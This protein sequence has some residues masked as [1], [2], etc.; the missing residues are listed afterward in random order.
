MTAPSPKVRTGLDRLAGGDGPTFDGRRVAL[1]AHPASVTADL[2]HARDVLA[3]RGARLVSLF[4]PEHGVFGAAQDM[5]AVT[6]AADGDVPVHSLYGDDPASLSPRPEHFHGADVLVCDLADIGVRY[7]TYA[8]TVVLA[9]EVALAAGIEVFVLDRPNP[10]GGAAD[11]LE[12]AAVEPGYDSFVGLH[13][14]PVRHGLSLGELVTLAVTERGRADPAGLSVVTCE[15]WD[16]NAM[17]DATGLA[18]VMPS[19]NMPTL[20]TATVY[21]GQCLLEGTNLSEGRGTTRPFELFG[22]PY[23]DG[24][25]LAAALDPADL[26]GLAVRPVV[27]EP[28]FHKHA[29]RACGGLQLHVRCR[30]AVRSL[31]TTVAILQAVRRLAGEAFALR[32]EPYEFVSD[33]PALDLLAGGP[34]LRQALDDGTAVEAL[35]EREERNRRSFAERRRPFLRYSRSS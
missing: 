10:L 24:R 32:T 13:D 25:A 30:R 12:G 21:P 33:R 8:W 1:L 35:L 11:T 29:G 5:V 20:D 28:T 7:Y 9:A 23:L 26:A 19:P 17:F 4:G 27:F 34:F 22:A 14:V 2:R 16:P 31:R 18:W 3:D 15:G 6:D